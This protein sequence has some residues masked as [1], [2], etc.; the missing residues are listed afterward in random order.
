MTTP[1]ESPRLPYFSLAPHAMAALKSLNAALA[2]STLGMRLI[3]LVYLRVSQINGCAYCVDLHWR[4]LLTGG[5]D[6]QRL[7]SLATW[8]EVGFFDARERTA[9]AWAESLTDLHRSHA[10]DE[11]F[12]ALKPHFSETEIADLSFAIAGMNAWNRLGIGFRQPV[13][14]KTAPR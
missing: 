13:V 11:D 10:D 7:N 5:E 6:A 8:R 9:L 1:H 14:R 2:A 4:D 12:N 3:D